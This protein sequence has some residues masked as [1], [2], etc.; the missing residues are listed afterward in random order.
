M[1]MVEMNTNTPEFCHSDRLTFGDFE[2]D[3][4]AAQLSRG[5]VPVK[6]PP[7]QFTLL[8]VLVRRAGAL[9]TRDDLREALWGND[10]YVDFDAG[11]NFSIRQLRLALGD[12]AGKPTFIQTVP[13]RGYRF[14]APVHPSSPVDGA[15]AAVEV[16][17][18]PATPGWMPIALAVM[19][20]LVVGLSVAYGSLARSVAAAPSVSPDTRIADAH[21]AHGF[22][23]LNDRWDWSDAE[24]AFGRALQ[25]DPNQEVALI[26]M[27]RLRASQGR[28]DE[29]I[30]YARRALAAHPASTRALVTLGWAQ[31]FG[32]D[33]AAALATC[34]QATSVAVG[35]GPMRLCQ[36]AAEAELGADH[37]TTWQ[38]MLDISTRESKPGTWFLRATLQAR[39]GRTDEAL[40]SLRM[41][42][43]GREP[44][45]TFAFVHPALKQL[46]LM[47]AFLTDVSSG[48]SANSAR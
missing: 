18:A 23:A 16:L 40:A 20:L 1:A 17:A 29:A 44:D 34:R 10:A 39:L 38:R 14:V 11:L 45:A 8:A 30:S 24:R 26:S 28:S 22:V 15:P 3:L 32:G 19:A 47:P 5:A 12:D 46:R 7:Q 36:I 42:I 2:L 48:F 6:L 41:A 37:T 25:L 43:D 33:A 31:L 9:V 21:A 4:R 13:R 35:A 27:S